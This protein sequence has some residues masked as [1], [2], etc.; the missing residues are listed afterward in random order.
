MD[1]L[2]DLSKDELIKIINSKKQ[3]HRDYMKNYQQSDKGRE[4]QSK[5]SKKYYEAN[6]EKILEKKREYYKRKVA[7]K[8]TNQ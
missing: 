4:I 1:N 5:A 6:R 7:L 3:N 8:A 2:E